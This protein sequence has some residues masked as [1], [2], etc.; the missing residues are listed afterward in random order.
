M[1][2]STQSAIS[3]KTLKKHTLSIITFVNW[4]AFSEELSEI[5]SLQ[6]SLKW[7]EKLC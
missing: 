7:V 4:E 1:Q 5:S 2:F 6:M 3:A